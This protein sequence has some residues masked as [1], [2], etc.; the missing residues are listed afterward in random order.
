[1]NEKSRA[2]Q[3]PTYETSR[4]TTKLGGIVH[5]DV[6]LHPIA[7]KQVY[8][9]LT[10]SRTPAAMTLAWGAKARGRRCHP[11]PIFCRPLRL[12]GVFVRPDRESGVF[13]S[14]E[15]ELF[16]NE[17]PTGGSFREDGLLEHEGKSVR[18]ALAP[19]PTNFSQL[20]QRLVR[21]VFE[22]G[23]CIPTV[24]PTR[25]KVYLSLKHSFFETMAA[26]DGCD[27]AVEVDPQITTD[28]LRGVPARRHRHARSRMAAGTTQVDI[29][30]G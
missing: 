19:K 3:P 6:R 17:A 22:T 13:V 8:S 16:R 14:W 9:W 24:R 7:M 2:E 20:R 18:R 15:C 23:A 5:E 11:G 30:H 26:L 12:K 21:W 27:E 28:D 29:S 1:M 10:A 4:S 25:R